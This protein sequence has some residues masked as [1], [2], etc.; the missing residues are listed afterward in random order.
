MRERK[1]K[2]RAIREVEEVE[3]EE[4]EEEDVGRR[5]AP[6]DANLNDDEGF[7]LP[8]LFPSSLSLSS[9]PSSQLE[10]ATTTSKGALLPRAMAAAALVAQTDAAG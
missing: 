2:R 4:E 9:P 6:S 10:S 7:L 5:R 3:E 1:A 8:S